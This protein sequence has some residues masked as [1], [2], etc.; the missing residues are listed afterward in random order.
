MA[1]KLLTEK[2]KTALAA[3]YWADYEDAKAAT[4]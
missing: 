3:D 4:A 1:G 2:Q